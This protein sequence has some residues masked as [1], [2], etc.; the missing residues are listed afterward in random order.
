MY[1]VMEPSTWALNRPAGQPPEAH[2]G[3]L[4]VAAPWLCPGAPCH[5]CVSLRLPRK[6][7][8]C[9]GQT[10][11]RDVDGG[12]F[13]ADSD[14]PWGGKLVKGSHFNQ[15]HGQPLCLQ[16]GEEGSLAAPCSSAG[17]CA[18][19]SLPLHCPYYTLIFLLQV[20]VSPTKA[21]SSLKVFLCPQDIAQ[22][23]TQHIFYILFLTCE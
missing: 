13:R 8:P 5:R 11:G 19:F 1:C 15:C 17:N 16:G 21:I 3:P 14:S 4:P 10:V 20:S 22:C 23:Q 2:S 7:G 9:V 18:Y 6:D 12:P